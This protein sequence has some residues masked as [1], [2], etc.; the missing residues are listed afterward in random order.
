MY[1]IGVNVMKKFF[2][3]F[4]SFAIF[5]IFA[6]WLA[7]EAGGAAQ[8][9]DTETDGQ[10]V[11]PLPRD[12]ALRATRGTDGTFRFTVTA[13]ADPSV[14]SSRLPS[15][16]R[17]T[18]TPAY[19]GLEY[20]IDIPY[21]GDPFVPQAREGETDWLIFRVTGTAANR[22][23]LEALRITRIDFAFEDEPGISYRQ[24]FSPAITYASIPNKTVDP[25]PVPRGG[26]GGCSAAGAAW[27]LG[28]LAPA[29]RRLKKR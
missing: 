25:D 7:Q 18:M 17:T 1:R 3:V 11:S 27:A 12:W 29:L 20:V 9:A 5:V 16:V 23:E 8:A 24:I 22:A 13:L 19:S 10:L 15:S 28:A 4:A 26:G 21:P 14:T 2:A 6:L